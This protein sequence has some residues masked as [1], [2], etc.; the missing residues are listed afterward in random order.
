MWRRVDLDLVDQTLRHSVSEP[1]LISEHR[2]PSERLSANILMS[3]IFGPSPWATGGLGERWCSIERMADH[4][5][6]NMDKKR[7]D[8]GNNRYLR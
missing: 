3:N 2:R 1:W 5:Q 7:V 4:D 6:N 8:A